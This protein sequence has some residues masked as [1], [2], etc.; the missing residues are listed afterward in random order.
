V[1]SDNGFTPPLL[2]TRPEINT[3]VKISTKTDI[4]TD[5]KNTIEIL[6]V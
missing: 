1:E 2:Y 6:E 3:N 4:Q 5:I